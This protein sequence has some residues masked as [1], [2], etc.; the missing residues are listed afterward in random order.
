V[1]TTSGPIK[2]SVKRR[3]IGGV[4][5]RLPKKSRVETPFAGSA[6]DTQVEEQPSSKLRRKKSARSSSPESSP[7]SMDVAAITSSADSEPTD[8][9]LMG[10]VVEALAMTRA[11]SMDVESIRKVVVVPF[12]LTLICYRSHR[13]I[14][15]IPDPH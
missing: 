2:T 12:F 7:V 1:E 9:S 13:L 3:S 4:D 8:Q 15:R 5:V 6:T 14:D 10:M 11:S